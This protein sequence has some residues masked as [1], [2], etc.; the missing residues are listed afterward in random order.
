M[1]KGRSTPLSTYRTDANSHRFTVVL[2]VAGQWPKPKATHRH[3]LPLG[4]RPQGG[5]RSTCAHPLAL[6]IPARCRSLWCALPFLVHSPHPT[7]NPRAYTMGF[8]FVS[9]A[10]DRAVPALPSCVLQ[11]SQVAGG[12][13]PHRILGIKKNDL[14]GVEP[15]DSRWQSGPGNPGVKL[16][17]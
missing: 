15:W 4:N 11:G 3:S 8:L 12:T 2:W 14:I 10:R 17:S 5:D 1:F 6:T 16:F 9:G 7:P 13:F